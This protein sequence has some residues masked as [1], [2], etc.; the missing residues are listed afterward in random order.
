MSTVTPHMEILLE[1]Q[2]AIWH[3]LAFTSKW[4]MCFTAVRLW[5]FA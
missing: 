4:A 2:R 5:P 1:A 3:E